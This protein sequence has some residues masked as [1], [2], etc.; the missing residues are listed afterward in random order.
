M[1]LVAVVPDETPV[2]ADEG[3]DLTESMVGLWEDVKES[4]PALPQHMLPSLP[5]VDR[6][7]PVLASRDVP[8]GEVKPAEPATT[9]S[10]TPLSSVVRDRVTSAFGFLGHTLPVQ[11]QG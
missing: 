1:A 5:H 6:V 3:V 7:W 11:P 10:R 9:S 4:T 8:E 2:A